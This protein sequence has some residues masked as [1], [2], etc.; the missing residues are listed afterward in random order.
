MRLLLDV[1]LPRRSATDLSESGLDATHL[2]DL[3]LQQ[4]ADADILELARRENRIV[5]TL[6]S[7]FSRLLALSAAT[8]PSVLYL[9]ITGLDRGRATR[10]IRTVTQQ[11]AED[12]A[13]GCIVTVIPDGFRIRPLPIR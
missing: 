2:T 9:R 11:C 7:D 3:G 1:G 6:D 12:L 5:V 10:V 13:R 8:G 4:L